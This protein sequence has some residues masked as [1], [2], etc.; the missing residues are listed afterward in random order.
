MPMST[1]S[2]AAASAE[3]PP[4]AAFGGGSAPILWPVW[5]IIRKA[6]QKAGL[7]RAELA[8]RSGAAPDAIS[9]YED[10]IALPELPTL[11]RIVEACGLFLEMKLAD[12]PSYEVLPEASP[13]TEERLAANDDY[14]A[15][16][17]E[18]RSGI[19]LDE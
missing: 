2:A 18:F 13:T 19:S 15:L 10:A 11:T 16:I 9:R 17:S 7:T 12:R 1:T 6:R 8:E 14:A 3:E 5:L 4:V